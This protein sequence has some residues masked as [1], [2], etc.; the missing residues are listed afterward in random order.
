MPLR[1]LVLISVFA[2]VFGGCG[3][4]D[5][6]DGAERELHDR[7]E[8]LR[9]EVERRADALGESVRARRER[10]V[11]R[12]EAVLGDLEQIIPEARVTRPEVQRA[13]ESRTSRNSSR[14]SSR[15]STPTGRAR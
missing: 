3:Q 6:R 14:A 11:A 2:L 5:V 4:E 9:A 12:I 13:P 10:I 1:R 7:T 8:L 15:T